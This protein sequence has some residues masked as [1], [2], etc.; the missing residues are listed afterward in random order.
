MDGFGT[1]RSAGL[2]P[3]PSDGE[4]LERLR[5]ARKLPE[6]RDFS[7]WKRERLAL[8]TN[9]IDEREEHWHLPRS[10]TLR[11][12]CQPHPHGGLIF[13]YADVSNQM[14]LE[15]RFNQLSSVQRTTI[16]HLSEA[17][18][19]FGTDGRLKLFNKAFAEI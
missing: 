18:A 14:E 19:V 17:L 4:I 9:V 12:T 7:S 10:V 13:I 16:D 1:W 5:E 15:R 6:Q 11:V 2:P 3:R 8:Y